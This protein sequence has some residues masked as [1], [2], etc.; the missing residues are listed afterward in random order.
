MESFPIR[1]CEEFFVFRGRVF[2][3][4]S[5]VRLLEDVWFYKDSDILPAHQWEIL[6]EF[7]QIGNLSKS[8]HKT[9]PAASSLMDGISRIGTK[10]HFS[11]Q[12]IVTKRK[13]YNNKNVTWGYFYKTDRDKVV[14]FQKT[15]SLTNT[16]Q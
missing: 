9:F 1:D 12:Q 5:S 11:K 2:L 7:V 16:L 15:K 8:F 10:R 13:F 14:F 4:S 6:G 3:D